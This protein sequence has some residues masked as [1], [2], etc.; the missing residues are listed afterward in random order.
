LPNDRIL[1]PN[2]RASYEKLG[3]NDRQLQILSTAT[4]KQQ[5]YYQSRLGNRLFDVEL[6]PLALAFCAASRPED[7]TL[8]R[9]LLQKHGREKFLPEYL[10]I[11]NLDW[12]LEMYQLHF[13][14]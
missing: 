5:Y 9:E 4:P 13:N 6:G 11:K 1:E 14:K 2:I 3:L 7:K 8:I 10:H 12:A